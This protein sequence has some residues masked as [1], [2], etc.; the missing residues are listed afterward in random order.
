MPKVFSTSYGEDESSWPK[1]AA[2]RLNSEFAKAGLRGISLLW[3]SGDRGANCRKGV[4]PGKG[5][6]L[7][8]VG[9]GASPY[10]LIALMVS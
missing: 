7:E 4:V 3:A 1:E 2:A 5:K 6:Q 9:P 10:V 8:V